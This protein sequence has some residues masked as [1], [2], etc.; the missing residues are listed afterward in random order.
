MLFSHLKKIKV[1]KVLQILVLIFSLTVVT[2]AQ[3]AI[4][5][6]SVCDAN[7]AVI[8]KSKVTAVNQN[9][10]KFE[11]LTNED[12]IYTLNLPYNDYQPTYTFRIAKY[13]ITVES[14]GFEKF[15][16]KDFKVVGKY[17]KQMY[18]DFALDAFVNVNTISVPSE[19][20]KP[21]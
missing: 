13:D 16:L 17:A 12:G 11:A 21:K 10:E 18:L 15:T 3:K 6:G 1:M 19:N 7:G 4:L 14:N 8:V 2:T 20:K 9:G 5:T